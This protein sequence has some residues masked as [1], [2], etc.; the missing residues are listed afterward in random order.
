M[1][2]A[3]VLIGVPAGMLVGRLVWARTADRLGVVVEHGLPWWAPVLTA[4][5]AFV[6]TLALAE[7][8]ARRAARGPLTLRTE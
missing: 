8:P 1:T 6:T 2:A 5:G 7:V 3:G 4:L